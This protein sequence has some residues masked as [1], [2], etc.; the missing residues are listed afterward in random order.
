[1][2]SAKPCKWIIS[3]GIFRKDVL[4]SCFFLISQGIPRSPRSHQ[5]DDRRHLSTRPTVAASP[6]RDE[7]SRATLQWRPLPTEVT[8]TSDWTLNPGTRSRRCGVVT[9]G[10]LNSQSR[11]NQ[12]SRVQL[13]PQ[14][15]VIDTTY[16]HVNISQLQLHIW[17]SHITH[18]T[19][20]YLQI[21]I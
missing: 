19:L 2:N 13:Y 21:Y 3:G 15:D 18:L 16:T 20:Y 17:K 11:D 10:E 4:T 14:L 7:E 9:R 5:R 1:M 6:D 8:W 12:R